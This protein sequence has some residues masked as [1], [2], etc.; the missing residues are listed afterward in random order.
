VGGAERSSVGS[1]GLEEDFLED[2]DFE[3]IMR[4]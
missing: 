1:G 4:V 2:L 3:G